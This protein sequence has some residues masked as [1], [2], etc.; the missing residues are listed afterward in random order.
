MLVG[1]ILDE[2]TG[3]FKL[4][5]IILALLVAGILSALL[6]PLLVT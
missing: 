1:E 6:I 4:H 3:W 5:Q 2:V